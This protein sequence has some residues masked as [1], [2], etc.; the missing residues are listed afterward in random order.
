MRT[1]ART[2]AHAEAHAHAG[3]HAHAGGRA[4]TRA[5]THALRVIWG[6]E[7]VTRLARHLGRASALSSTAPI[8]TCDSAIGT[9]VTA[10]KQRSLLLYSPSLP[11][12][13]MHASAA[14]PFT[15][16]VNLGGWHSLQTP[17]L[18]SKCLHAHTRAH[19]HM[20]VHTHH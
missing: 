16:S 6:A 19:T 13:S 9:F 14:V 2:Y 3:P 12:G 7:A 20:C 18:L 5:R 11:Y 17:A 8:A 1:H 15:C 10:H 4:Y